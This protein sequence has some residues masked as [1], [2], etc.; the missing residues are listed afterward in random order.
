MWVSNDNLIR[1][2]E[3]YSLSG[4]LM[5]VTAYPQYQKISDKWLPV[6]MVMLDYFKSRIINGKTE[7]ERT[8][9]SI[10][11]PSVEQLPDS[12]FTKE[13]LERVNQ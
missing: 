12:L 3:D 10:S 5:R 6:Q 9:I 2:M 4:Q 8:M 11:R 1:K 7:Y 13:Y